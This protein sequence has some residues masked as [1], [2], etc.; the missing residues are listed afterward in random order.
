M[1]K[2]IRK[3]KALIQEKA[4]KVFDLIASLDISFFKLRSV[5]NV[6]KQ[7]FKSKYLRLIRL[8]RPIPILLLVY[9]ILWCIALLELSVIEK[10]A[11]SIL[12][13]V[14]ALIARS[15]GCIVNDLADIKIDKLVERT[16]SRPL[17]S[18]EVSVMQAL[19]CLT[20]LCGIGL[21]TF[22]LLS[23]HS[24]LILLFSVPLVITYPFTKRFLPI[25]QIFLGIVYNIGVFVAWFT[26]S[27]SF[28]LEPLLIYISAVFWTIGYDTI[29]AF[30]DKE[31]DEKIGTTSTVITLGDKNSISF[32][33]FCY[34][35]HAIFL[36]LAIFNVT[37]GI[38]F[39]AIMAIACLQLA[40]QVKTLN[41]NAAADCAQKFSSNAFYGLIALI[42]CILA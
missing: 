17:A 18:G 11:Y 35:L 20:I 39:L 9:P 40:W 30:Q 22:L 16:R 12:F 15:A 26:V 41:H 38:S 27:S 3:C 24:I 7:L 28:T 31:Y 13:F 8:D 6:R 34:K 2:Y 25:P 32:A 4:F 5:D 19:V 1:R 42:A 23:A 14:G 36:I 10:W 29:Y 37:T 21:T 33:K